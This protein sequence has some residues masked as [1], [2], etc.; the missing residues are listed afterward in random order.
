MY[1][2]DPLW[3]FFSLCKED[4]LSPAEI[5]KEVSVLELSWPHCNRNDWTQWMCAH[6][7]IYEYTFSVV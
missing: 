5:M 6:V 7:Y 1:F 2:V 3:I 4:A